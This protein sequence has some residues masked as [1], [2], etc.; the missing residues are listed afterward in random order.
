MAYNGKGIDMS[1]ITRQK[2]TSAEALQLLKKQ[3]MLIR[4]CLETL[5]E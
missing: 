4:N 3:V 5:I 1:D 2:A